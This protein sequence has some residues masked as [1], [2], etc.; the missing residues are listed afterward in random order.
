MNTKNTELITKVA[1]LF[2]DQNLQ[3]NKVE[4]LRSSSGDIRFWTS[5]S[6]KIGVKVLNIINQQLDKGWR[7]ISVNAKEDLLS[8]ETEIGLDKKGHYYHSQIVNTTSDLNN[9][10]NLLHQQMCFFLVYGC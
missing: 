9:F 5:T 7:I 4:D 3:I 2:E 8:D 6:Y 10:D 1:K